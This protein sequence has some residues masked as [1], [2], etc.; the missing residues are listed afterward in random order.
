MAFLNQEQL[1]S[2]GFKSIGKNVSISDKASIYN[3]K[4]ISIGNNVR[5]DD[6]CI[7]S[8][9]QG[10]ISL[11]DY[12]HIACYCAI[13]G[14][15]RIVLKN[16]SGLSARVSIYS[17]NDDYSGEFM[18]NPCVPSEYTN[19]TSGDVTIEQHVIIGS[20]TIVL[21]NVT[22]GYGAAIGAMSLVTKNCEE[23]TIYMGNPLR[24]LKRRKL[25]FEELEKKLLN[26]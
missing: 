8:A 25:G 11:G 20:G 1:N 7:L 18:T 15:G 17:S 4:N 2:I 16:F 12:I 24:K 9:G 14:K 23:K 26:E 21:P 19:V 13:I 10:G 5:I 22:V 3:P 6:F